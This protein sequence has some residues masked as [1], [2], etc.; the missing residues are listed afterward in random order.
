MPISS[1]APLPRVP[2]IAR[3][4]LTAAGT[5]KFPIVDPGKKP[6]FGVSRIARGKRSGRVKY[7]WIGKT[8]RSSNFAESCF[9][10]LD[11]KSADMSIGTYA[12]ASIAESRIGVFADE[13]APNSTTA[14]PGPTNALISLAAPRRID[15]SVRLG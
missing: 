10:E 1:I 2:A 14:R 12:D 13:P 11:R 5:N 8:V 9:T 7:H 15:R 6:S 3:S 4:K